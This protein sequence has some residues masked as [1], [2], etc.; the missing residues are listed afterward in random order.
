M[1]GM[2]QSF[3]NSNNSNFNYGKFAVIEIQSRYLIPLSQMRILSGGDVMELENES[4]D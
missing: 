2:K 1:N 4:R 3:K